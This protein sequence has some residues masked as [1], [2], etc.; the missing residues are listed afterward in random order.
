MKKHLINH[1]NTMKYLDYLFWYYYTYFTRREKRH[2]KL[3]FGDHIWEA[4]IIIHASIYMPLF[5]LYALLNVGGILDLPDMPE[6]R[7]ERMLVALVVS[8]PLFWFLDNRYCKN[9]KI[10]K[11]KY[12]LFRDRWG[13]NPQHNKK[14]RI[15]VIIY[16]VSTQVLSWVVGLTILYFINKG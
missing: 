12:Q 1:G 15:A 10:T 8:W 9:K 7:T 13:E 6:K 2:P 14:R 4:I 11:N 5:N 16:T 3:F